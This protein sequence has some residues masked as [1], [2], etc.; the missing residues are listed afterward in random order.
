MHS[1]WKQRQG[2]SAMQR[3]AVWICKDG[4]RKAKAQIVLYLTR[5]VK[6]TSLEMIQTWK[7]GETRYGTGRVAFLSSGVFAS[8]V[9]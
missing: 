6:N 7:Y 9:A 5:D 1:Q 3:D 2:T 8:K 4:I